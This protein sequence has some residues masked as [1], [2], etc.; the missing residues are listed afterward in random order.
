MSTLRATQPYAPHAG[1]RRLLA[2]HPVV[3]FLIMVYAVTIAVALLRMQ[4]DPHLPFDLPLWSALG[5]LL[6][7][8]LP[9]FLVI[10]AVR[11][12]AGLRD[13]VRRSF[14]WRVG[15]GWYVV[16]L[17][18]LP[19]ATMLCA[20]ALF[21][22]APLN[23][24]VAGWPLVFTLVLPD[25]LLR[26]AVLNLAEEIGWTG[27]LQAWLQD[28]HGP[29]KACILVEVPFALF[30]LPDLIVDT[31]GDLRLAFLLLG[32][33]AVAQ[34]FGRVVVMWLYNSAQRS[35]LLV[36]L[37]HATYNTTVNRLGPV[38]IPGPAET[39]FWIASSVVAVT[40]VLILLLTR[41]Q[42]AYQPELGSHTAAPPAGGKPPTYATQ[43]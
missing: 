12:R 28:R 3:A 20:S 23:A 31:G 10:G 41:G 15:T 39:G 21:G 42:L 25:L 1:P 9:A 33:F 38:F 27:F 7:V 19:T 24:L 26:L 37:F 4:G 6:G 32:I 14:R 36:G 43:A 34:L 35:L 13:L 30:H 29:W 5:H 2:R 16:A 8:A 40:A 22:P 18:G 17:L 11:G